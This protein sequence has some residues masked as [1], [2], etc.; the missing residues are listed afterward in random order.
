[1]ADVPRTL[2]DPGHTAKGPTQE[3]SQ[4]MVTGKLDILRKCLY[5]CPSGRTSWCAERGVSGRAVRIKKKVGRTEPS[6]GTPE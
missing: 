3:P 6:R 5:R 4:L 1:M 2:T